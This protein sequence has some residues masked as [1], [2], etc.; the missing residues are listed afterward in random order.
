M[1]RKSLI[2]L[3]ILLSLHVPP[4]ALADEPLRRKI[5]QMIIVGF[6]GQTVSDSVY[7][8]LSLR[9]LGGVI[10]SGANGN[11]KTPA[12]I[13]QLTSQ[14][15]NVA[16]TPPFIA[17]DQEGG[18]VAR[19]NS[20]NGFASTYTAFTLG[21][22]F[23][24]LDSSHKQASL[25]GSWMYSCG[26]NLNFA[27][28]ADVDVNPVSPA[29]GYYGRSFS[30]NPFTVAQHAQAFVDEFHA[31]GIVTTLKHFP[32]HGSAGTDSH[33]TLPDITGTWTVSE[34][35][36]YRE[37]IKTK[38]VD[39]VMIGHL[40]NA[41][42][43]GVYPASLSFL[44][45]QGLLRDSLHYSG[46]AITDDLY[47]MKAITDNFG[48]WDAAE[49]SINAGTDILLYVYNLYNGASL[50]RQL[51][52][53]LESKVHRGRISE[54]RINE[55][56]TRIMQLKNKYAITMVTE[57]IAATGTSPRDFELS[58][59]PNPFNPSTIIRFSI[60]VA[61]HV[62]VKIYDLL[63]REVETLVEKTLS[64][65]RYETRW[66]APR[67]PSGVYLCRLQSISGTVTVRL[68]LLK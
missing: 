51:V 47:N 11:L 8:D 58:N 53:S 27:P 2:P 36:P 19:L 39:M 23:A 17:T 22:T 55:A 6:L 26:M 30:P 40:F 41:S 16:Q 57:P 61:G 66:S 50:C 28:V 63:G 43:D 4:H 12:Q 44:T 3:F 59:Y 38:S 9:N 42:I 20:S 31:K 18:L 15:R 29:I 25:M 7:A 33:L 56:Y 32:G 13:Q 5:G 54:A 24:S 37:L 49:K 21:T 48:F 1:T 45:V 52:D 67:L 65:G 10:L 35:T 60:P 62:T 34:L 68:M 64:A 46:V 14:L